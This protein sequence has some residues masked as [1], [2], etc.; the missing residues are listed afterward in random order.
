MMVMMQAAKEVLSKSVGEKACPRP[1]L[2]TGA[3]VTMDWPE[4]RCTLV[5]LN[6]SWY[7]TV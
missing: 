6:G 5:V 2:S 4:A 7:E 3:S 1:W